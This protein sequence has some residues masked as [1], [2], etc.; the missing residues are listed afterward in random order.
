[1]L[2]NIIKSMQ[3]KLK[4]NYKYLLIIL[5]Y[6]LYQI[7][8][9]PNLISSF[10]INL[11]K[12]P[13]TARLFAIGITDLIYIALLLIIFKNEIK[14]GITDLKQNFKARI[15]ISATCWVIGCLIMFIST[16]IISFI[17]K[18]DVSSNEA[19]VRESIKLAPL[20]MLFT[21]SIVAPIF[22]EMV[23][24]KAL[25]GLIKKKWSFIITS[26]LCFGLLHII[27]SYSSPLDFLYVIPYGAM[28]FSF[29]YLLTKTNNIILPILIHM[30]HNT[31]LVISQILGG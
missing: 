7:S 4:N 2:D 10:G 3:K 17:V 27:G 14:K 12:L 24:R 6:F 26:G 23:F 21:C 19:L 29:A 25:Y 1:M 18:K 22:E 13:K 5:L 11:Y 20:Y 9:I 16:T 8:F 31:I 15:N 28:G 30:F